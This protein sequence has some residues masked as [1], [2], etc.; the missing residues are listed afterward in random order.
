[1]YLPE[2]S[3]A[4]VPTPLW[5]SGDVDADALGRHLT[6][7]K[8]DGLDGA[9][10]LGTNGEFASLPLI[11]R[12]VI[13]DAAAKAESGLKLI[14]NVGSCSL[15]E[16]LEM[17]AFGAE[18]GYDALMC[19]PPWY[20]KNAPVDGLAEFFRRVLDTSKLP[21][22]LYHIPQMTG[23]AISDELLDAIGEHENLVGVKDS[24]GIETEMARLL[25]RFAKGSYLVGNDKLIA[26]CYA[27]GGRGSIS[28]CASVV[29]DLVARI[30]A[31]PDQQAKLNSVRGMLE[32]FG[33]GA[34]VK[35][36]LKKKGL[37]DYASQPP[38]TGL[39]AAKA[40]QLFAMLN[41][42]GVVKW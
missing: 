36:I 25:P 34:A 6:W 22:L 11:E 23:I 3:F 1:M 10:I 38:M 15:P 35:A 19:P 39:E 28:A 42:F 41:M 31:K 12:K 17:A 13:A 9:L 14:L 5:D 29:P 33:L 27:D 7:L 2:G 4:P 18:L 16:A 21:V 40:E 26:K 20:F 30:K 8:A 32:K 37:G 24:T